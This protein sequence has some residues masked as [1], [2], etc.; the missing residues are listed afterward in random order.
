MSII[1]A[2]KLRK[3]LKSNALPQSVSRGKI[4]YQKGGTTFEKISYTDKGEATI[5]VKS[6]SSSKFYSVLIKNWN[7]AIVSSS[8]SCSYD[9][10]GICKHRVAALLF[11]EQDLLTRK[12]SVIQS[13]PLKKTYPTSYHIIRIS[14]FDDWSLKSHSSLDDW[15]NRASV[16]NVQIISAID[17]A[18]VVDVEYK[19]ETFHL[20]FEKLRFNS[21]VATSCSC[22][23]DIENQLCIHKIGALI[24]IRDTY[25]PNN[26]F[27][28]MRDYT[29]EKNK[30]LAEYGFSLEDDLQDKFD[31][32]LKSDGSVQ[33]LRLDQSIQKLSQFQN[34]RNINNRIFR[35]PENSFLI[36]NDDV[37]RELRQILYVLRFKGTEFVNDV[38]IDTYSYKAGANGKMAYIRSLKDSDF[39]SFPVL[40][41]ADSQVIGLINS[42]KDDGLKAFGKKKELRLPY[43][44][45][46]LNR[47]EVSA[48][49]LPIVEEYINKKLDRIFNLLSDKQVHT[50]KTSF[51]SSQIDVE[52]ISIGKERIFP[53]FTL[54]EEDDF[55]VLEGFTTINQKKT[56]LASL[57]NPNS[58]WVRSI[59][60]VLYK[61]ANPEV[62]N[63]LSYLPK[64]GVIKVRKS[65]FAGFF[66]DFVLPLAEKFT[67]DLQINHE[68]EHQHSNFQQIKIYLKEDD[69]N[70]L[71][72][73]VYEYENE[74]EFSH[75]Q[76]TNKINFE[77][78]KITI[79]HRN[80]EAEKNFY[81][82]IKEQHPS[83]EN[84]SQYPF[85]YLSFNNVL[86][87]G[88][89]YKF[90]EAMKAHD[91]TILGFKDLKKFRYN[92]HK[93]EFNIKAGSGIDW[94]DMKIEVQ[95]GD[96][97]IGIKEIQKAVLK[98]QNYVELKDG[99]LGMLP[100][101]WLK[102][103]ENVLKLGKVKGDQ[104]QLSKM[105][106]SLIDELSKDIDSFEFEQELF[107]KKQKLLNFKEMAEIALPQNMN[108]QLRDYQVEGFKWLNFLDEFSWGGILAD[109]MGLGKTLQ[110][111]TFL[112]EQQNRKPDGVNLV[113][114]P[115]TLIF[116]WQAEASKFCPDLKLFVHR[117]GTRQ[118]INEHWHEY[119]IILTTYG[120]VRSD[121][122]LFRAFNFNYIILDESQAIKNPDSLISK[123]V[124]LLQSRNRL[125]MTG[126]PVENNTFDLYSQMEFIN[127]GLLGSGEF[128]KAEFSNPIDKNQDKEKA[129]QLRKIVYPFMLKRTKEEVAKDLPEKTE[130]IIYCEMDKKQRKVYDT[131]RE[132][133]RQKLV[134]KMSTDGREKAAFL[135]LEGLLKLRQICDSPALLNDDT[136]Y[137]TNSA[138]LEEIIREIEENAGNH[139]ILIFSQF[140]KMLD[141]IKQHLEKHHI[142]YEYLDGKT[143]DRADRVN[144]F[145]D[146]ETCRVFL[147]SLKAGGVG[148]N[149]TE[150][151]YVYL[152]D[153]WWNPAVE[154]QAIDRTHRIGQKKSVFA[155]RMI[156]KDTIEEKILLLQDKKRDI[157]KDIISTEDGFLKKLSQDD[158]IDLFS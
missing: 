38:A 143:T 94:F 1:L 135:I 91:I 71:F 81:Q 13:L 104:L 144:H 72:V 93:A 61:L 141:L 41:D 151:D 85:F 125:V 20:K 47:D 2:E 89:L 133:Y 116:N 4:I 156:C 109:D 154:Q 148:I 108:A 92:P 113:V 106:F 5:K 153:P 117:G 11:L 57:A 8:C 44:Y 43:F 152:V 138:K 23:Q 31:F 126:T 75:D 110:M 42:I 150:A 53:S 56:K 30:L 36:N 28:R 45:D 60:N 83:F 84:Q 130:S 49:D 18:A 105:H 54:S 67:V 22:A 128:F 122:E 39:D 24:A 62:A 142:K 88:W 78:E 149:L 21:E 155:Y 52:E 99:S 55:I 7:T 97:F 123:A 34:W 25:G 66:Q 76:K 40:T 111:L 145:Q 96:Q 17:G 10:G 87:D 137:D 139:K 63:L 9:W 107:E 69:G 59:G 14:T 146:D 29:V 65:N 33:L 15:K 79:Q 112:Q 32:K 19:K 68:I 119:D 134:D 51:V 6:D 37:E 103:Y 127:P 74:M 140:L 136:E 3:Y 77:N 16:Q 131:F 48:N 86:K 27:D 12:P 101:E 124:K 90:F 46:Y 95:F 73:P 98:K 64:N 118:K 100:E 114:L 82:T 102:R 147:M 50:S 132:I 26:P 70:L 58:Y 35:T 121:I 158:I 129:A 115:T 157:A 120:M 80:T